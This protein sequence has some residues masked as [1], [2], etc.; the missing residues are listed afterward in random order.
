MQRPGEYRGMKISIASYIVASARDNGNDL[1][2]CILHLGFSD[3]K[4][5]ITK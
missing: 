4:Q 1:P 3:E 5:K 2:A